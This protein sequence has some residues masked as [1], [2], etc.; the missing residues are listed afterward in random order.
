MVSW[1][2]VLFQRCSYTNCLID[3]PHHEQNN[4]TC[5]L[6]G[7]VD[8]WQKIIAP[9]NKDSVQNFPLDLPT[10]AFKNAS[11]DD[12]YPIHWKSLLAGGEEEI[13]RLSFP[14]SEIESPELNYEIQRRWDIDSFIAHAATLGVHRGGFSLSY[15]PSYLRRIVQNQRVTI[16]GYQ[17]HKL[18]QLR[19]GHGL[20]AGGFGYD[21][22]VFFPHMPLGKGQSTHLSNSAQSIWLD[23]IVLPSLRATCPP[24]IVQHHPCSFA[25]ANFKANVK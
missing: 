1:M 23:H 2:P 18:K 5:S 24:D 11:P 13:L 3:E 15:K 10:L 6:Q 17:V 14:L 7:M 25:D 19:L 21:C 9:I 4:F 12:S 22:H 16:C 20:L 8:N